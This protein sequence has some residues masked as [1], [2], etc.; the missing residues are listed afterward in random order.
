M[1]ESIGRFKIVEKL[2]EGGMGIVYAAEDE[3]LGR[4]VALKKLRESRDAVARQRLLREAR[5]AA[6]VNHPNVCQVYEIGED[7]DELYIVMELIDGEPLEVRMGRGPLA[8]GEALQATLEILSGLEALHRLALV[9]RDIKPSNVFLTPHGAKLLDFGLARPLDLNGDTL[10]LTQTGMA[11]GTPRYM[12]PEQWSGETVTPAS[13][14]FS[15]GA[16]LFEMLTSQPA[17]PGKTI[18]ETC[19]AITRRQPPALSGGAAIVATDRVIQRA[20]EKKPADRYANAAAMAQEVRSAL[21]LFSTPEMPLVQRT[22]RFIALP[23]RILRADA[24]TDFLA[25]SLPDAITSSLAALESLVVRS[26]LTAGRFATDAPDLPRLAKEAEVDVVLHGTVLRAGEQLRVAAQ[27][28]AVPAGTVL[29]SKTLQVPLGDLFQLQDS[30]VHQIVDSLAVP[31]SARDE[32]RLDQEAPRSS[33]AYELYLRANQVIVSSVQSSTLMAARDLYRA[34]LAED[35]DYAPAWTRLARVYRLMA[36]FGHAEAGEYKQRAEEAFDRALQLDPD[37][38]IAHNYVTYQEVES[39]RAVEAM[40]RLVQRGLEQAADPD[41]YAGLVVACRFCGLLEASVAAD[42]RAKRL[43]PNIA[44]S[45]HFT[46]WMQGD[47]ERAIANDSEKPAFLRSQALAMIGREAESLAALR[48]LESGH[49]EGLRIRVMSSTRA[50]LELQ[51]EECLTLVEG[52]QGS[53]FQDP[54]GIYFM[55]RNLA[56]VEE[57]KKALE[58]LAQVVERGFWCPTTLERDPWL[59]SLRAEPEFVRLLKRAD[60]GRRAAA[61]AYTRAGGERLLGVPAL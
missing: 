52:L 57:K 42:R 40:R 39:G 59:D 12:A 22:T 30:L 9:H 1:P 56:R 5:V 32:R 46:Y 8:L 13:D 43:D 33:R 24:D 6:S 48:E 44:T 23:F 38:S 15:L 19:E 21:L 28:V 7:A 41:L 47:Y 25:F 37:L 26:S 49:F 54:E 2:G 53:G 60:E 36:K 45:V 11:V 58:L 55:L 29:W 27:L 17:F 50:A 18:V 35:P 16:L 10:H 34:C 20:L 51:R 61:A 3:S 14:L 31:L 4:R